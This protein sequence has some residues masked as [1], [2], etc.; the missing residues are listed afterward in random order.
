M[1][2]LIRIFEN[3]ERIMK[4][5]YNSGYRNYLNNWPNEA[6]YSCASKIGSRLLLLKK[7]KP[8]IK[9]DKSIGMIVISEYV[10]ENKSYVSIYPKNHR[11]LNL[12]LLKIKRTEDSLFEIH[13][14]SSKKLSL[15]EIASPERFNHKVAEIMPNKTIRYR[16]N[17]KYDTWGMRRGERSFEEED[18]VIQHLGF[19][20]EIDFSMNQKTEVKINIDKVVN[21]RKILK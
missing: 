3:S 6:Q 7:L 9:L 1:I 13:V 12:G 2:E 15:L 4:S 16:T 21:E 5:S 18:F 20:D 19:V 10:K 8:K 11:I 17:H 14:I